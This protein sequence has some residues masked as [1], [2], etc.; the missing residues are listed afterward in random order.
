MAPGKGSSPFSQV[1]SP[2]LL[3]PNKTWYVLSHIVCGDRP[4]KY[5]SRNKLPAC[6][7]ADF[8]RLKRSALQTVDGEPYQGKA[9]SE[10]EIVASSFG[11]IVTFLRH[12]HDSRFFQEEIFEQLRGFLNSLDL[13]VLCKAQA[14]DAVNMNS[15]AW[16]N[17]LMK[18]PTNRRLQ[19]SGSSPVTS[20]Q[21]MD[22]D[23]GCSLLTPQKSSKKVSLRKFSIFLLWTM[24]TE[25]QK[26]SSFV[27]WKWREITLI[28]VARKVNTKEWISRWIRKYSLYLWG[29]TYCNV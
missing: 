22:E 27:N 2:L 5:F 16:S 18:T 25:T 3:D 8:V 17:P 12:A 14:V 21:E 23:T 6:F 4:P 20:P 24:Q 11:L 15:A 29:L 19:L 10:D 7:P 26:L 9:S 13:S 28:R 1:K